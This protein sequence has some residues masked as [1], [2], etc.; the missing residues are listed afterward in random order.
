MSRMCHAQCQSSGRKGKICRLRCVRV[1]VCWIVIEN[2]VC[3]CTVHTQKW[4]ARTLT[5]FATVY[6]SLAVLR[7]LRTHLR[8]HTRGR[9]RHWRHGVWMEVATKP[10]T[11]QEQIYIAYWITV[12]T[13]NNKCCLRMAAAAAKCE[14]VEVVCS[15][16]RVRSSL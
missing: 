8:T 16:S 6:L 9:R 5:R 1:C 12:L 2:Y 10:H 4:S 14:I 3:T 15:F 13:N 7:H 11:N